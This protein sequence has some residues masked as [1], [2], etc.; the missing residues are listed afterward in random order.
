MSDKIQNDPSWETRCIEGIRS[1]DEKSFREVF[2]K[3]YM[4]LTSFAA[5]IVN[6]YEHGEEVVQEVLL[7]IWE[8]RE[9]WDPQ[10][11]LKSYLY[12]AVS[13]R[14]INFIKREKSH[15]KNMERYYHELITNIKTTK[16]EEEDLQDRV[17]AV[18][19]SANKLPKRRYL[20]FV[21]H[22]LHGLSYKEIATSLQISVKTVENQ[23]GKALQFIRDDLESK[24]HFK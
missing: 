10:A 16:E 6:S 12:Q 21:L 20:I 24:S 1:G 14:S 19:A 11:S 18:W 8:K 13:N 15:L 23:M 9:T 4:P 17:R 3:Y 5:D 7:Y 22:K 2:L